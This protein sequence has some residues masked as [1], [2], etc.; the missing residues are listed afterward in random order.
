[1]ETLY[2]VRAR[3]ELLGQ[4]VGH[5]PVRVIDDDLCG[6]RLEC[7]LHGGVDV[8]GHEKPE[9]FVFGLPK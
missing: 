5:R 4:D 3:V 1:V 8:L 6:S 7:T 9:A 2:Q